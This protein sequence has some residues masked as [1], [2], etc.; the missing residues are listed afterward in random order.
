MKRILAGLAVALTLTP[1]LTS[2]AGA[3]PTQK[4]GGQGAL[5]QVI[6][7]SYSCYNEKPVVGGGGVT[8]RVDVVVNPDRTYALTF[9]LSAPLTQKLGLQANAH[10]H[11]SGDPGTSTSVGT[12]PA[13]EL[14]FP[15]GEKFPAGNLCDGHQFDIKTKL[16]V[17]G[18]PGSWAKNLRVSGA[19]FVF[20]TPATGC[21]V[22]PPTSAA[23]PTTVTVN[24][25]P[26]DGST[27]TVAPPSSPPST[28]PA[29]VAGCTRNAQGVYVNDLTGQPCFTPSTGVDSRIVLVLSLALLTAGALVFTAR[30]L[31]PR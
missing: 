16:G 21:G 2:P 8:V 11:L 27:P 5:H 6:T 26:P 9:T 30:R 4:C 29:R 24:S 1:L 12:L 28:P 17:E 31:T 20:G 19:T 18:A 22:S 23:P 13:G 7:A 14:S 15:L 25:V 10:P 3:T